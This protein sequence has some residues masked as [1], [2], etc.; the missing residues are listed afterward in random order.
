MLTIVILPRGRD[1]Q[2]LDFLPTKKSLV[3]NFLPVVRSTQLS[4]V[5]S[6]VESKS[7]REPLQANLAGDLS[8]EATNATTM[9]R[10]AVACI[11]PPTRTDSPRRR[12][13]SPSGD[14]TREIPTECAGSKKIQPP[15]FPSPVRSDPLTGAHG[16]V[17]QVAQRDFDCSY[18]VSS[19]TADS[20]RRHG[21]RYS[22]PLLL[23]H[24]A[25]EIS[26]FV[27]F[28][29]RLETRPS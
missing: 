13:F 22:V 24:L 4:F 3:A 16:R 29:F 11:S 7:A 2:K 10:L 20:R 17:S 8:T 9:P 26:N 12:L 25:G 28:C 23:V 5:V 18:I 19:Y 27:W 21:H 14:V 6:S 1:Q 15:R